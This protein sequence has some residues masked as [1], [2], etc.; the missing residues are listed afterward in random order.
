MINAVIAALLE[1]EVSR[2]NER[3]NNE[4]ELEYIRSAEGSARNRYLQDK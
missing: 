3:A 1:L 2:D 4:V